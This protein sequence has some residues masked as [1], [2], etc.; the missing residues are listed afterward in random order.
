MVRREDPN[1]DPAVPVGNPDAVVTRA[2]PAGELRHVPLH[3]RRGAARRPQLGLEAVARARGLHPEQRQDPRLQRVVFTG[4]VMRDD[5]ESIA[6]GVIAPREFWKLVVMENAD[7]RKLHATA[8]LLS[9]GDLIRDLLEKRS[10]DRRRRGL[11]PRRLTARSR[12]RSPTSPTP[13]ATTSRHTLLPI[14][15][16][17]PRVDR[18]RPTPAS[19]SS[20]RSTRRPRS[21]SSAI[22]QTS[23]D[24]LR[25][26]RASATRTRS[27]FTARSSRGTLRDLSPLDSLPGTL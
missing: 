18:R 15:S 27:Q 23:T 2:R 7:T 5:D 9:Q 22:D 13:R 6:P 10:T 20:F 1:W 14:P 11:R 21:F 25:C 19:R 16:W 26:G 3:E 24:S 17:Q 12:S 8:Y 4:P